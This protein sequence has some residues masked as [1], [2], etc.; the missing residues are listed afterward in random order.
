MLDSH[1]CPITNYYLPKYKVK[2]SLP[3]LHSWAPSLL[4][5]RQ[6]YTIITKNDVVSDQ[7]FVKIIC[8]L[9]DRD[10]K[11]IYQH[12][13]SLTSTVQTSAFI[14][15]KIVNEPLIIRIF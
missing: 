6:F 5:T 1:L 8:L 3:L 12:M 14:T 2:G 9:L 11:A 7:Y 15:N 13:Q 4:I 10:L